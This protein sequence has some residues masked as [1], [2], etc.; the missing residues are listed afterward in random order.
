MGTNH[1]IS[2][3][4]VFPPQNTLAILS[5]MGFDGLQIRDDMYV[6]FRFCGE[7][8][9]T[10]RTEDRAC[11]GITRDMFS[12]EEF[13]AASKAGEDMMTTNP[14]LQCFYSAHDDV[15]RIRLWFPCTGASCYESS[16]L[17]GIDKM[18]AIK[19]D[20]ESRLQQHLFRMTA[21]VFESILHRH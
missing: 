4:L 14:D 8:Y 9:E 19:P 3:S 21:P 5:L 6:A 1:R 13:W 11:I 12:N 15:L 20:F 10:A 7:V 17:S 18:E 16:L 2:S